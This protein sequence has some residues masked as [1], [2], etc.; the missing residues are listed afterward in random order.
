MTRATP[1]PT[2]GTLSG[3]QA[4]QDINALAAAEETANA[5]PGWPG[6]SD[7]GLT[8]LASVIVHNTTTGELGLRDQADTAWIVIGTVDESGKAFQATKAAVAL[9]VTG[10]IVKLA[11]MAVEAANAGK[12]LGWDSAGNPIATTISLTGAQSAASYTTTGSTAAATGFKIASGTDLAAIFGTATA[13][14]NAQTT[15]SNAASAAS[16]AQSTANSALSTAQAMTTMSAVQSWVNSQGFA[17]QSWV[18]S[19]GYTTN[20]NCNCSGN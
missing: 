13:V 10:A 7:L 20:C 2:S 11:N 15:A 5:G 12:V 8:S 6:A 3:V 14:T 16:A 1:L 4:V 9:G 19:Q 17:T 18:Q